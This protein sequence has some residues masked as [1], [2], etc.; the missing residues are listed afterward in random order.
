MCCLPARTPAAASELLADGGTRRYRISKPGSVS[1][2]KSIDPV[3]PARSKK[4]RNAARHVRLDLRV[5]DLELLSVQRP[6]EQGHDDESAE[7]ERCCRKAI[8]SEC[9]QFA[10][11]IGLGHFAQKPNQG[12]LRA[13]A[14]HLIDPASQIR[15]PTR[16]GYCQPDHSDGFARQYPLQDANAD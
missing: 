8:R 16:L 15:K 4:E 14:R 5:Q 13:F 1:P 12:F 3:M 7:E 10:K 11:L 6:H 2:V 9:R